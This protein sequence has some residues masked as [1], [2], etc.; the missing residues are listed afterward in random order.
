MTYWFDCMQVGVFDKNYTKDK[1]VVFQFRK[2]IFL[3]NLLLEERQVEM[4]T[5]DFLHFVRS[6]F[7]FSL[8]QFLQ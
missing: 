4:G 6:S 1:A 7:V 8:K 2:Q 5:L 3:L